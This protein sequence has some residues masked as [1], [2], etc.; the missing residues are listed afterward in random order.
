[1]QHRAQSVEVEC[2]SR[3]SFDKLVPFYVVEQSS[4][5]C[6]C[7]YCY[8]AKLITIGLFDLWTALHRGETSASPCT[9]ECNLCRGGGCSDYLPYSSRKDVYSMGKFSD[10]HM[11][12]KEDLYT[13]RDGTR[14]KAHKSICVT[15]NCLKCRGKQDDFFNCPRHKGGPQRP[16]YPPSANPGEGPPPG[17]VRWNMFTDVDDRG[18]ATTAA[19]T[20][21]APTV[22]DDGDEFIPQGGARNKNRQAV[23]V[24][25]GTV[26]DLMHEFSTN[27]SNYIL[28]R[29]QNKMQR[30]A[31]N[32]KRL[33]IEDGEVV[34]VV[35]FQERLQV[36][37]QDQV[38]SQ[39]WNQ[40][41][42]II[43]PCPIY[44]K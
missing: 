41:A 39:Y 11:C 5:A 40:D 7:V 3:A 4:R 14:V 12:E 22:G 31:L 43:F 29:R 25:K 37:E 34:C 16:L 38:Q 36:K 2:I 21:T 28:H 19:T 15:G 6:L 9:C 10:L 44:F 26:D 32:E 33:T 24:K 23:A 17:E 20:S 18:H 8:K 42:T 13:S 27:F 35:D 1:M 30:I